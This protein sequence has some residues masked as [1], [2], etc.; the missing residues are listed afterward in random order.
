M[1]FFFIAHILM[2]NNENFNKV[3]PR[4]FFSD[5]LGAPLRSVESDLTLRTE[6]EEL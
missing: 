2:N 6:L 5:F 3:G 1:A 4:G